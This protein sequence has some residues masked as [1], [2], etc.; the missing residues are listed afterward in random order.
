MRRDH[1]GKMTVST[2]GGG[3][4]RSVGKRSALRQ[5]S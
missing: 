1:G 4:D 3:Q 2:S 5:S